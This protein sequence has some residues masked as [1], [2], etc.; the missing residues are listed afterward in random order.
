M[1]LSGTDARH[2][3]GAEEA[4]EGPA[5]PRPQAR[6]AV[7]RGAVRDRASAAASRVAA[8]AWEHVEVALGAEE[9]GGG[10][11][12]EV[13]SSLVLDPEGA[14][15]ATVTRRSAD[16]RGSAES[17]AASALAVGLWRSCRGG[18]ELVFPEQD[19]EL[20]LPECV[21]RYRL[22]RA[23]LV[24]EGAELPDGLAQ[25]YSQCHGGGPGGAAAEAAAATRSDLLGRMLADATAL[26]REA[27]AAADEDR[28]RGE[29]PADA[30]EAPA[31][32]AEAGRPV[33][34]IEEGA[35]SGGDSGS[36]LPDPPEPPAP[37]DELA[38]G[39]EYPDD[40]EFEEDEEAEEDEEN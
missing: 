26:Q 14:F 17:A 38:E 16:G 7:R 23:C 4:A 8:S 12:S 13:V 21:V 27:L 29:A 33:G 31:A 22:R 20:V 35:S 5:A 1:G 39:E 37:A 11:E 40:F 24:A 32:A 15:R 36:D 25:E 34:I 19:D 28:G 6:A 18:V 9:E 10:E 3:A 2:L 30:A